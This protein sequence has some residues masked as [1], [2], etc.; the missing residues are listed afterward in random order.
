M[1]HVLPAGKV[2]Q[3][4]TLAGNPLAVAAGTAT[5][6]ELRDEPPTS[7]L[8]RHGSRL[9]AGF[10]EAAAAR[11]ACRSGSPGCGSMMT[12]FFQQGPE[13]VPVHGWRRASQSDT[14]PLRGLLLGHD[15][16]RHLHALQ[17]V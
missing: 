17:P 13:P 15:R 9:E 10:R 12:M 4:G 14:R 2:F 1:D 5:L 7:M 11:A 3:A 6:D 8:E 16:P